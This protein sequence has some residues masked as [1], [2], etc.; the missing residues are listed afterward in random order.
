MAK[1]GLKIEIAPKCRKLDQ[2]FG[3]KVGISIKNQNFQTRN[4]RLG[5]RMKNF[6]FGQMSKSGSK[7]EILLIYR[8][9]R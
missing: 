8:N 1:F 5:L 4:F 3:A 6:N 2:K 9:I 7:I